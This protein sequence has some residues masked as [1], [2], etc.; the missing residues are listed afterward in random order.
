MKKD[1]AVWRMLILG[2]FFCMFF[3]VGCSQVT[4]DLPTAKEA[5]NTTAPETTP[6][7]TPETPAVTT[8]ATTPKPEIKPYYVKNSKWIDVDITTL[9]PAKSARS[10]ESLPSLDDALVIVA[11]YNEANNDDQLH[12]DTTD[13]PITEAPD[14]VLYFSKAVDGY[15]VIKEQYTITRGEYSGRDYM[16]RSQASAGGYVMFVDKVPETAPPP[17]VDPRTPYEKY[18]IYCVKTSDGSIFFEEHCT[19]T[20]DSNYL[21]ADWGYLSVE[22][23]FTKRLSGITTWAVGEGC[24]TV[25]GQIYTPPTK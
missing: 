2:A 16:F 10:V 6:A 18:S 14:V 23:Y 9:I 22:E 15:Y 20:W 24:T 7:V 11:N 19:E 1:M 8:P 12:L 25:S 21:N 13:I 3:V 4:S 17:Y 5:V